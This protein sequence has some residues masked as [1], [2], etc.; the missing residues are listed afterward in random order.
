MPNSTHP[1]SRLGG[2]T[3]DILI[4]YGARSSWPAG[5]QIYQKGESADGF[6]VVLKG[7]VILRSRIRAG[8]G[9]IPAV[10]TPG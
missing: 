3:A 4:R 7:H 1:S 8:R 9:F 2:E 10:V 6:S 5:F